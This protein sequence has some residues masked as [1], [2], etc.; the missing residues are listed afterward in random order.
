MLYFFIRGKLRKQINE[1]RYK[2]KFGKSLE[3]YG[4]QK[5]LLALSGGE[6]S[7]VLLDIIGALLEG[8]NKQHKGKQG[9]DLVVVNLDESEM[10]SLNKRFKI[11]FLNFYKNLAQLI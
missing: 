2:V 4:T 9:F 11:L 10:D 7:I 6:S 5:V 3:L 1:E 8:Q